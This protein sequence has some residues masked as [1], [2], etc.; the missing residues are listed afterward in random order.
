MVDL[1]D[2]ML[3]IKPT[4]RVQR[5]RDTYFR[6]KPVLEI[7]RARI[8]TKSMKETEGEP[9]VIRS[10]KAFAA[11]VR[12]M[13]LNIVAD[14]LLVGYIGA[15][16]EGQPLAIEHGPSLE[17]ALGYPG[18]REYVFREEDERELMEE[19]LPYWRGGGNYEKTPS[20]YIHH[21]LDNLFYADPRHFPAGGSLVGSL[22][23]YYQ[24][25]GHQVI[26]YEKVLKKG[27]LGV[28]KEAEERLSRLDPSDP[29]DLK[30]IPF[31]RA[32][33][34]AM[35]GAAEIGKRFADKAC[36]LAEEEKNATRRGELLKIAEVCERVPAYPA[37]TFY[38]AMQSFWFT[39]ILQ[40]W[41]SMEAKCHS[42][43][44]VDQY[45]C[46]FYESDI[47]AGKLTREEAQELIDCFLL[48]IP[49]TSWGMDDMHFYVIGDLLL[50]HMSV[51]GYKPDGTDATNEL[52]YM[53]IE[54]MMHCRLPEPDFSVLVHGKAP[55]DFIIK[56]CQL[57]A[58]GC[59]QPMFQNSDFIIAGLLSRGNMGGPAVTI[60]DARN[61]AEVG[62]Q[63]PFIVG[64]DGIDITAGFINAGLALEF[65]LNN[66]MNRSFESTPFWED[67]TSALSRLNAEADASAEGLLPWE[68]RL[69]LNLGRGL[70]TGDPRNFE[71]FDKVKNAFVRQLAFMVRNKL[72]THNVRDMA[73]AELKPTIFQSALID[74]CI[75]K[76][77]CREAGGAHYNWGPGIY[78]VGMA[79]VADSLAAVKKLVFEEQRITMDQLCDALDNNFQGYEEIRQML[80]SVPKY[81]N[82]EDC[83]DEIMA[84]AVHEWAAEV[85][86]HKNARGGYAVCGLQSLFMSVPYGREVGALPSGRLAGQPL[87]NG[88]S[89]CNGAALE[90]PTAIINSLSK[91]DCL[92]CNLG[93][94]LNVR[95]S[96]EIFKTR[97]GIRRLAG[98][99]RS[100]VDKQIMHIQ[101][102]I[103]STD[104]LRAAQREP[105][106]YKDLVVRVAG[107]SAY[108][109]NLTRGMQEDIIAKNEYGL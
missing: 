48:R 80:L 66:G 19:I 7:D 91:V 60:E 45:F 40:Y 12:G 107:Y 4:P 95:L 64:K 44:R 16:R 104:T 65:A 46:P 94:V 69:R 88:G 33:I 70:E 67:A 87:S 68:D 10:A 55:D 9:M 105:D 51:G 77:L 97:D 38:E 63:E 18:A 61:A 103:I 1:L 99:V 89:P 3:T 37:K 52:S 56:G 90:S 6:L 13:P 34:I 76:G 78:P 8:L 15:T 75:E 5:L 92:E 11:I 49:L 74:D 106:K 32:V 108:F 42:F 59:G 86:K 22:G 23:T 72:M 85:H 41:E 73:L 109:V 82:D 101:F 84:W 28:K 50:P 53:F 27:C 47:R 24:E 83:A 43:G 39:Y 79:D 20:G 57:A 25:V 102:N 71:S 2:T 100:I 29:D 36:E 58:L 81:G 35:E 54:G 96:P 62:C 93:I 14:E 30:K 26:N 98:L 31:V 17:G 21:Y